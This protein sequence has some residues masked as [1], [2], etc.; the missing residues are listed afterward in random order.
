MN[1]ERLVADAQNRGAGAGG[2]LRAVHPAHHRGQAEIVRI[3]GIKPPPYT[4]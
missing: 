3:K 2:V 4:F 1:P